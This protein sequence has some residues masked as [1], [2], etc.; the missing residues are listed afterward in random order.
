MCIYIY[1][2]IYTSIYTQTKENP[3]PSIYSLRH[4]P[5]FAPPRTGRSSR[6]AASTSGKRRTWPPG[7]R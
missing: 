5:P 2:Y 1:I 7:R 4:L 6:S 3:P